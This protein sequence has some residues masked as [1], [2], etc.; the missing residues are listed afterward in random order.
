[1]YKNGI[2]ALSNGKKTIMN[3]QV[4]RYAI[5]YSKMFN[6]PFINH[7]EIIDFVKIQEL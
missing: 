5:E 4:A 7:P 2:V 3:A 1:M 6:I